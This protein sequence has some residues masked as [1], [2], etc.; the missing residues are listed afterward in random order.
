MKGAEME[1]DKETILSFLR[2]KGESEKADKASQELPDRVDTDRDAGL[3]GRLGIDPQELLGKLGGG[4][5][6]L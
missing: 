5:P 4:I 2:E 3:L 6:G 1:F